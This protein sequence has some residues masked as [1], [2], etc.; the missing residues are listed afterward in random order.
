M[1][2]T[3]RK[4]IAFISRYVIGALAIIVG[5]VTLFLPSEA[6]STKVEAMD[7]KITAGDS[8]I[9]ILIGV[10]VTIGWELIAAWLKKD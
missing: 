7:I 1:N 5:T 9:L 2:K 4:E 8:I 6:G 3:Q 10:V